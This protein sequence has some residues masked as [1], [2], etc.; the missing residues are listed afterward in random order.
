V[1]NRIAHEFKWK[2]YYGDETSVTNLNCSPWD[3]PTRNVQAIIVCDQNH[4]WYC[5]RACDYYWYHEHLDTWYSGEIFGLF[6]YLDSPGKKR[7]CFGRSISD[8]EYQKILDT[9][10]H[11]MNLPSK[12][13]WN[14]NEIKPNTL[15]NSS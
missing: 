4:G 9:A 1:E 14:P 5:C 13:G 10:M 15:T 2:I 7:V 3:I 12:T 11:D 6:D 8:K